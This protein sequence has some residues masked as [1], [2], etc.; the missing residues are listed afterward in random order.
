MLATIRS[1]P[2]RLCLQIVPRSNE[3]DRLALC[4]HQDGMRYC[5][6]ATV[7]ADAAQ[8]RAVADSGRA[9][10][11]VLP[12]GQIVRRIDSV[13]IFFVAVGD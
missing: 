12:V 9:E 11:N 8:Q 7:R 2:D 10:N 1:Q 13:E 3:T 6:D 5:C 4:S